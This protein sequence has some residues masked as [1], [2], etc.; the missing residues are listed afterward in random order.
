MFK[1]YAILKWT[2]LVLVG[3]CILLVGFGWWFMNLL[4]SEDSNADVTI[5]QV[6]DIPYLSEGLKPFRGKILA[7]VTSTKTMGT[8][9]K[10][11]GYELTELA[12]AY[13]VFQAN[14]TE[15]DQIA[16]FE[17]VLSHNKIAFDGDLILGGILQF[18]GSN[19]MT[20]KVFNLAEILKEPVPPE[21]WPTADI[22][23]VGDALQVDTFRQPDTDALLV[24]PM[25]S[26]NL[27]DCAPVQPAATLIDT[28]PDTGIE[29]WR[30]TIP[31]EPDTKDT[32]IRVF[33][34]E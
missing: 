29:T 26:P 19:A 12:R 23:R 33:V 9:G 7:V 24:L 17:G 34:Q 21:L 13:Y 5:T 20:G 30:S 22:R 1:K 16:R 4:P 25:A 11:T 10:V 3:L 27:D 8:S 18:G 15:W 2:L 28:D 6:S 32:F 31:L 14:G